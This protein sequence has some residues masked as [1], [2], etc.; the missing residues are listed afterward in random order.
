MGRKLPTL[1]V[2]WRRVRMNK[3]EDRDG[4]QNYESTGIS[5]LDL[6]LGGGLRRP[7]VT[8]LIGA[9][10][11][12]TTSFCKRFVVSSLQAGR[13][14]LLVCADEPI[15]HYLRNFGSI[16][17]F[18]VN[19]YMEEKKLFVVD[20]YEAFTRSVGVKDYTDLWILDG[21]LSETVVPYTVKHIRDLGGLPYTGLNVVLDSITSMAPF[22]GLRDIYS[23]IL[24]AQR[25]ARENNHIFLFTGHEG[26]LE[27][28][29]VQALRKHVDGVIRMRMHWVRT[30][31]RREL[32]IEKMGFTEITQPVLEFRI[33]ADGIEVI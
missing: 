33:G 8:A 24:E 11:C 17:S 12:G 25:T 27:G 30:K 19:A 1:A 13:R 4:T 7:S 21:S 32:I 10:G 20:M 14:V 23:T 6:A 3:V 22:I 31:L 5:G 2:E 29:F 15:E 16:E 9:P 28:N 18:D 26:A